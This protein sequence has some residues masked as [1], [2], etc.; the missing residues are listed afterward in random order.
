MMG[1]WR[2]FF[3]AVSFIL[4]L[5]LFLSA[6]TFNGNLT[7]IT[8][9]PSGAPLPGATLILTSPATGLT[10]TETSSSAGEYLFADLPVGLYQVTVSATGFQSRKIDKVEV[11]VSRTTN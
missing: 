4:P 5:P 6:Q 9:D 3:F 2:R 11:A 8:S 10:R 7:G 1:R